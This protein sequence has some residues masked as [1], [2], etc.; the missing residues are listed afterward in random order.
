MTSTANDPADLRRL[1]EGSPGQ[2]DLLRRGELGD[3]G[4]LLGPHAVRFNH[5]ETR[6]VRAY[7]PLAAEAFLLLGERELPMTALGLGAFAELIPDL[8]PGAAYRIRFVTDEGLSWEREDPYRFASSLS[9]FDLYLI[10]EGT[11]QQ[12][13][14]S[15]GARSREIDGVKG[16]AFAVWAPNARRVSVV[17]PFC[18]WDGRV[19]PMCRRGTSGVFEIFLPEVASGTLYKFEIVG[20]SGGLMMKAD[21][22]ARWA[23]KP[24]GT[25]SRTFLSRFSWDDAAWMRHAAERDVRREAMATYEVHLG[26]W[27]HGGGA[28]PSYRELAPRLVE[29]VKK[30]GFNYI[31]LLPVAEHP[32]TGSWGY[33]ITGYFA[34]T[35]RYGDPDDFRFFVD[36][37][38]RHGVGVILDWVPA[39]F[40]KD[41]H[42]LGR[43]DGTA[44]YEH[45]DPRRGEHPDWGTYIF[46]YGRFE[47]RNFLV[48]NA[49][50]WF[51]TFHIDGLR[52]D[53][54]AS[55]LYLDYSRKEGEWLPNSQGGRENF[56]AIALLR[57]MNRLVKTKFPGRF[58]I[59][60]E[61]TAWPG[62][63]RDP[64]LGGLG[65]TFKW[66][67]GWM[68]D[69]LDYFGIDPL[70]RCHNQD[71][72]TFGMVYEYSEAFVNPLSHD[73]VV[74]GKGSLWRKMSGDTW[75]K[76][77]NLRAL[78]T[79]LYTR[80]GK[81][82]LFM[83]SEL[84]SPREWN[85]ETGLD[86]FLL[87]E[88]ERRGFFD[89]VA[90]L[91]QLYEASACLWQLDHLPAGFRWISCDDRERSVLAFA[92][93]AEGRPLPRQ[94]GRKGGNGKAAAERPPNL[95]EL[96]AS[97]APYLIT[98][99]NLT[100]I[101]RSDYQL[102]VPEGVAYRVR[103]SS[104]APE[105]GGAG[106]PAKELYESLEE[107]ADGCRYS[108]RLTLPPLSAQVLEPA[109]G[110]GLKAALPAGG[111]A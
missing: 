43:F 41:A 74:H 66:N 46:N 11:H 1:L 42:G 52:V 49:L 31:E 33:Q 22:L 20:R 85:H 64:D 35:S 103:L 69:T 56:E 97:G 58:V 38:H 77:A 60:E 18:G 13:W 14:E 30:L 96:A 2:L 12:L 92:R 34:P 59:A 32:Y 5:R 73:E 40:V 51:D 39:H 76:L 50:Y 3:P 68:H 102:G 61:S 110:R 111:K 101:A 24:P 53:A 6:V 78:F 94:P 84:A 26:S 70:F 44:L 48:A 75:R 57:E 23:E 54:V 104:D 15:L 99:L 90:A 25:A 98:V 81:K 10:S 91:G 108:L 63:T 37:C 62:V 72:L 45:E 7:H 95:E 80:P 82:L 55:M 27:H 89:F 106:Y 47:V 16:F 86:W 36:Y 107:P 93:Y 17:G 29:H 105:F 19:F 109:K 4:V 65:F 83:G 88:K 8:G 100:P 9:E 67:M 79:Y 28:E 87:E 71:K 21:P